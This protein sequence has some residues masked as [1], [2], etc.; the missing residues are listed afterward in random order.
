VVVTELGIAKAHDF[1]LSP[2][3]IFT[4]KEENKSQLGRE[5]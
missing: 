5:T 3:D 4:V 2:D 1:V